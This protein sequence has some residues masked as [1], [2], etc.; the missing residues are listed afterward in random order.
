MAV[1]GVVVGLK[2]AEFPG[3]HWPYGDGFGVA[4][5]YMDHVGTTPEPTP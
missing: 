2:C 4:M 5:E 1:L 3:C